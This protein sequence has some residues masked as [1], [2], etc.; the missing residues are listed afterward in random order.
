MRENSYI[1][2][3]KKKAFR[4]SIAIAFHFS[5]QYFS[6]WTTLFHCIVYLYTILIFCRYVFHAPQQ[7]RCCNVCCTT[8]NSFIF[9]LFF[10]QF[11][12]LTTI[13]ISLLFTHLCT[14][15]ARFSPHYTKY[16]KHT[17]RKINAADAKPYF[18]LCHNL[19]KQNQH[20]SMQMVFE[21][22]RSEWERDGAGETEKSDI[23]YWQ[24][25]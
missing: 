23:L 25:P 7:T 15:N 9:I 16:T 21:F 3:L 12:W 1:L 10:L 19:Y 18:H 20:N 14:F 11:H 13:S 5:T 8:K 6:V 24:I 2:I 17:Y 4:R 22:E